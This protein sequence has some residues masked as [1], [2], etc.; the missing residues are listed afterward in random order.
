VVTTESV[1][2]PR[3]RVDGHLCTGHGLCYSAFP[4]LFGEDERGRS[5]CRDTDLTGDALTDA[6]DAVDNCPE[7]AVKIVKTTDPILGS[8]QDV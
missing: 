7:G 8:R 5:V 6:R 4:D 1:A 3:L 2:A